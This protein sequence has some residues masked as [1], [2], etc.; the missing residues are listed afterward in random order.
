MPSAWASGFWYTSSSMPDSRAMRS[1]RAYMAR[2]FH[3]VST[4][5]SG[6]GGGAGQKAFFH[7]L[8]EDVQALGFQ[9]LQVGQVHVH[10]QELAKANSK[11]T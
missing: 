7:H 8:A 6:K 1:R 2:N 4:C 5:S 10:A 9:A 3:V 11:P